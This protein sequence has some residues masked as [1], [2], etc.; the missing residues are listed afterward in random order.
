ML[1][2]GLSYARRS[3]NQKDSAIHCGKRSCVKYLIL[4]NGELQSGRSL[5]ELQRGSKK[6]DRHGRDGV[7]FFAVKAAVSRALTGAYFVVGN[8]RGVEG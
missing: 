1:V 5:Q 6:L 3:L 2:S 8:R 4:S 7:V